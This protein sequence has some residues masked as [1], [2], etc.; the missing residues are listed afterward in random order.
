MLPP[1]LLGSVWGMLAGGGEGVGTWGRPRGAYLEQ[2][3]ILS[4]ELGQ[5]DIEQG[6]EQQDTLVL[7]R[8]LELEV[9]GGGEHGLDRAHAVVVVMLGGQLLRAQAVRR[10][11]LLGQ[12][13]RAETGLQAAA[14][15]RGRPP[16]RHPR[17]L[18]LRKPGLP[19]DLREKPCCREA[20]GQSCHNEPRK[21]CGSFK[22]R[23]G[24]RKRAHTHTC[25]RYC[26]RDS[27]CVHMDT[28]VHT[29]THA[30]GKK[31][32]QDQ[33]REPQSGAAG[34]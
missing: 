1:P 29:H 17:A 11:D 4:Q 27:V 22:L 14:R 28:C 6:A 34:Y 32:S 16:G 2:R 18:P 5:V 13:G 26:V 30:L 24:N 12:A 21:H 19:A 9:A 25:T 33:Q 10:H 8:V 15:D 3:D 20:F 7:L 31:T 23:M